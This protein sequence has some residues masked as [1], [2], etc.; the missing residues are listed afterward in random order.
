MDGAPVLFY[1]AKPCCEYHLVVSYPQQCHIGINVNHWCDTIIKIH[2]MLLFRFSRAELWMIFINIVIIIICDE[3]QRNWT[4]MQNYVK[5][6]RYFYRKLYYLFFECKKNGNVPDLNLI[7]SRR[8]Y[9][10]DDINKT[11]IS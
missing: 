7:N 9:F 6:S 8:P 1:C 10:G 2:I 4:Y 5:A 11:F 3:K